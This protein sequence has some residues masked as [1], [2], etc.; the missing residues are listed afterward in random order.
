MR[1]DALTV[2]TR[3]RAHWEA[4]DLGLALV[5]AH[6][7]SLYAAWF[8]VLLPVA[9]SALTLA[10]LSNHDGNTNL[11]SMWL[12]WWLKPLYD[13]VL[14]HV[15]SRAVFGE[16]VTWRDALR[17]IPGLLRHS[18][19][20]RALTWSRFSPQRS[21]RLPIWQL[22]GVTGDKR[23]HRIRALKSSGAI[24]LTFVCYTFEIILFLGLVGLL[25]MLLPP[26]SVP[27]RLDS[28]SDFFD[29]NKIPLWFEAAYIFV[30]LLVYTI[31]EPFYVAAGFM[32]YL[33]RRTELEG[34]DIE[35]G[36]R[37]LATRLE[38]R[39]APS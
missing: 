31:I 13:R 8:A 37:T 20:F 25:L 32:L 19:L 3:A 24:G 10:Y 33:N 11:Y 7:K 29:G 4:T 2:K 9:L 26:G 35:L 14:L 17:A 30:F 27:S 21:F 12:L 22:E 5:Q 1:P 39:E 15:M 36:F 23:G 34:W 38:A 16:T 18:G 28:L 6:R